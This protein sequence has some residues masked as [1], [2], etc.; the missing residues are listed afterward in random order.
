MF[1]SIRLTTPR[2]IRGWVFALFIGLSFSSMSLRADPWSTTG[3][4]LAVAGCVGSCAMWYY[5]IT[6]YL[7]KTQNLVQP[8]NDEPTRYTF[9]NIIGKIPQEV[10]NIRDFLINPQPFKDIGAELPKGIILAGPPGTGKTS[11][12]KALAGEINARFFAVSGTDLHSK[13]ISEGAKNVKK[14]FDQAREAVSNGECDKAVI[15]IDEI[16]AIGSKRR[17]DNAIFDNA[18]SELL[19]QLDGF[20]SDD[21]V[22]LI[23]A[24]NKVD[25]LDDALLRGC[26]VDQVIT[27][28]LPD[29]ESRKAILEYY[30]QPKRFSDDVQ[31]DVLATMS[32]GLSGADLKAIINNAALRAVGEKNTMIMQHHVI[33]ELQPFLDR[34]EK[35]KTQEA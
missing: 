2:F 13:W 20:Y 23:G 4:V 31:F 3:K 15:F 27:I 8:T 21:S 32:E 18:L 26:R 14:L 34:L 30:A 22:F 28:G 12:A 35:R 9:K 1:L 29:T 6:N 24:T 7:G 11:I 10:L 16:E 17:P 19:Q 25:F 33:K 5:L